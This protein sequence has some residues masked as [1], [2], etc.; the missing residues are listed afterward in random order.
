MKAVHQEPNVGVA[1]GIHFDEVRHN[2][3]RVGPDVFGVQL[4]HR[5]WPLSSSHVDRVVKVE[6]KQFE[7][8]FG[9]KVFRSQF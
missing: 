3:E 2:H 8:L 5:E 4:F 1:I 9:G 7:V 6:Q